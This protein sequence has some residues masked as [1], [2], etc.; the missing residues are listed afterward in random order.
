[1]DPLFEAGWISF[2]ERQCGL[3][4]E[5]IE[6][7]SAKGNAWSL[8]TILYFDKNGRIAMPVRNSHL[9]VTFECSSLKPATIASAKTEAITQL[10]EKIKAGRPKASLSFSP[11]IDDVRPFQW[12]GFDVVPRFTYLL[13]LDN[14]QEKADKRLLRH[15]RRAKEQ[16]YYCE[17]TTD[18]ELVQHCLGFSEERKGF[19]HSV[20]N[21]NIHYLLDKMG[22]DKLLASVCYSRDKV[23]V[24][25]RITICTPNNMAHAWSAG[26]N[27]EALRAGCNPLLFEFVA[28]ELLKRN[29]TSFDLVGANIPGVAKAKSAFGGEL[30]TYYSMERN[31]VRNI[32]KKSYQWLKSADRALV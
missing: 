4:A 32:M 15:A 8:Q 22:E 24:G 10:A 13:Q 27:I 23:P 14:W 17:L 6:I 26:L 20:S 18:V 16:G 29:C 1:M 3:T 31:T 19:S 11:V 9:P 30:T 2:N 7:T 5:N 12:A 25:A 21:E 28:S